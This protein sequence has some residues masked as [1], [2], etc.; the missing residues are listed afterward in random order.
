MNLKKQLALHLY[1]QLFLLRP[2][3]HGCRVGGAA[4]GPRL[5]PLGD[6]LCRGG[7]TTSS[8]SCARYP[9]AWRQ[10]FWA[11]KRSSCSGGMCVVLYNLLMAIAP[12]LFFICL[13]M[14]LNAFASTMFSGTF[15]A[16]TYDS[17]KQCGRNRRLPQSF[18]HL[19]PDHESYHRSRLA[20][21]HAGT[22]SALFRLLPAECRP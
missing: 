16:L 21:Q 7:V 22:F 13:A 10:T 5:L 4:G 9:A 20:C 12:N 11:A 15:S 18:R 14:G 2:A 6:R 17:L 1:I 8:V 19:L 3:H